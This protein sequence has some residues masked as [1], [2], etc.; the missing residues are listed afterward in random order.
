MELE[1][2]G[3][4]SI[5]RPHEKYHRQKPVREIP[6][7]LTMYQ[8]FNQLNENNPDY[9]ALGYMKHNYTYEK[10]QKDVDKLADALTKIGV[11]ENDVVLVSLPTIPEAGKLLL[12]LS[13][14]GAV[15]KWID[16]RV[17]PEDL[18]HYINEH[19]CK[20]VFL[21]DILL[22]DIHQIINNTDIEKAVI[23]TPAE[24]LSKIEQLGYML[25]SKREEGYYEFP[26]DKRFMK[27][28]DVLKLGK[29]NIKEASF[30]KEKPTLIVQSSGTTGM[31]KS[32]VHTDYSVS[33]SLKKFAYTDLPL[34]EKNRM[35]VVVPPWIAYGLINTYYLSL[36]LGMK[37]ELKPQVDEKTVFDSLGTF[38]ISFAAPLHYHYLAEKIA[39]IDDLKGL[40]FITG[41]D[42]MTA[43]DTS[44][45]M[46]ILATKG[47]DGEILNGYG[48]NEVLG[49]STVNPIKFNKPGTVGIPMHENIVAAFDNDD[50]ELKFNEVGELRTNTTTTFKEYANK[51]EETKRVKKTI[52]GKE[53]VCS[54]DLGFVDED[55][56]VHIEGRLVNV[57][58]RRAFKVDP[59]TI[60]SV[61]KSHPAVI[62][63]LAVGVNDELDG[64]VPMVFMEIDKKFYDKV[65]E[66][67]TQ[68]QVICESKLKEYEVPVYFEIID[69]I[70]YTPNN[71]RDFKYLKKLG[72]EK[73]EG[74]KLTLKKN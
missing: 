28:K 30:D 58:Y 15:S 60:E 29:D 53:W 71:K 52:D 68:L 46:K 41:G 40:T 39:E 8:I 70:P 37:A 26:N 25:K 12:A 69:E 34:E 54:G 35:L 66:V 11:K 19:N 43:E 1:K 16:L 2:T 44:K 47:F 7:N 48:Q 36:A 21:F 18:E 3:Y 24:S 32:I 9:Y 51:E 38:D 27:Y 5:D 72:N 62:D 22:K 23:V 4:V 13:K 63:A 55:G 6:K 17:K 56:F 10:L 31:A 73:L 61:V 64:E 50:H 59:G 65:D 74:K 33:E 20:H 67:N 42:K 14:V 57:I 49:G 45:L